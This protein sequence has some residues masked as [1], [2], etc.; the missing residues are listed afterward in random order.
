MLNAIEHLMR[1]HPASHFGR[2]ERGRDDFDA[3]EELENRHLRPRHEYESDR[4]EPTWMIG[5][6]A[7]AAAMLVVFIGALTVVARFT[8]DAPDTAQAPVVEIS[9]TADL[10]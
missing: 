3:F 4:S 5:K 8:I 2:W 1:L 9:D 7:A 6:V 10:R